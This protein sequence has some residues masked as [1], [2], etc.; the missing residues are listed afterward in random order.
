[1]EEPVT[2]KMF[3][4][5]SMRDDRPG[6]SAYLNYAAF[7]DE[8]VLIQKDG[9]FLSGW[10]YIG[11]DLES[12]TPDEIIRLSVA[13]NQ[14]LLAF[15]SDFIVHFDNLRR[16][17]PG[18]PP[19]GSFPD[20]TT[21]LIN[22]ERRRMA[23]MGGSQF[24]S[25]YAITVAWIAPSDS[26]DRMERWMFE[27]S[28]K[29]TGKAL[30]DTMLGEFKK[31]TDQ[32]ESALRG[33]GGSI[34]AMSSDELLTYIHTCVTGKPHP[35]RVPSGLKNWRDRYREEDLPPP[36]YCFLDT[37][38]ASEDFLGGFEPKVGENH[39]R[40]ISLTGLPSE[41]TP[42]M[43]DMLNRLSSGYR[44]NTRFLPLS[45]SE[46]DR[47]L[48][49]ITRSWMRKQ[50]SLLTVLK[51]ALG[52]NAAPPEPKKEIAEKLE[53]M[54]TL[55]GLN[56]DNRIRFGY[57]NTVIVLYNPD[58]DQIDREARDLV[59]RLGEYGITSQIE[60]ENAVRAYFGSLP[61]EGY[62]NLRRRLFSSTNV[63]DLLP[64]TSVWPGLSENRHLSEKLGL[65]APAL[66]HAVSYSSTPFR[67]NLHV[68]DVGHT[69]VIG[70]TGQGKSTLAMLLATQWFRYPGAQVVAFDKGYSAFKP[71]LATG[72]SHYDILSPDDPQALNLCPLKYIGE[73]DVDLSWGVDYIADL[74]RLQLAETNQGLSPEQIGLIRDALQKMSRRPHKSL[75]DFADLVQDKVI[76]AALRP[77]QGS[78]AGGVSLL[79]ARDDSIDESRFVVF[80]TEHLM[81]A[82]NKVVIPTLTY[83]FRV[84][85]RRLT[86]APT[87]L[88]LDEAWSLLD[89]PL[90]AA[91]IRE[92]LKVLRK[93]ET[94]VVFFSQS[95]DDVARS[96]ISV[97]LDE[98]CRTTI[99]LGNP[100]ARSQSRELYEKMGLNPV[101]IEII[102]NAPPYSYYY[103]SPLGH[104]L[105][106]LRLGPVQLAFL[107]GAGS[108]NTRRIRELKAKHGTGW[109]YWFLREEGLPEEAERWAH[110][111]HLMAEE[112]RD[113]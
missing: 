39:I 28:G 54:E 2:F 112:S 50:Y 29:K 17:S 61:G 5:Q 1:M 110:A 59:N 40:V 105:F 104:R 12:A 77:Y 51:G 36:V 113:A 65:R 43:L 82:G 68:E 102:S 107:S 99:L 60:R 41:T 111:E 24:E 6:L 72:G 109:P 25:I 4:K 21:W 80:E 85:E 14:A 92:W 93:A 75:T 47:E 78:E 95:L 90:F 46:A 44:W 58:R 73:S 83:L 8:G 27:N 23:L 16:D 30:L 108:E 71:C 37:V 13:A 100:Q 32:F 64:L 106:N 86:G 84:I 88:L 57:Y 63:A 15:G 48:G 89:H 34:H 35:V 87:L 97:A 11:P 26:A 70:P 79:D 45:P 42:G 67:F 18:Y 20:R 76:K 10:L 69:K 94:S 38:V 49:K 53:E 52:K 91:R 98:S 74:C 101:Q 33:G 81:K 19:G 66:I 9:S 7:V 96:S 3:R 31:A 55:K 62:S 22:D 56:N 103:L